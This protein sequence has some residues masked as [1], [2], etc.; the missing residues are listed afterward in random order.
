MLEKKPH[1]PGVA[2][3]RRSWCHNAG[4][5][6]FLLHVVT[7]NQHLTYMYNNIQVGSIF[8]CFILGKAEPAI[9]P[10]RTILQLRLPAQKRCI[11]R[12]AASIFK[13]FLLE[14]RED[15]HPNYSLFVMKCEEDSLG[16]NLSQ[17]KQWL[18]N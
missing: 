3:S 12:S 11:Q 14:H 9:R 13:L 6:G 2:P 8:I 7:W 1:A 10:P 4:A 17:K 15:S 16:K 5:L 18:V